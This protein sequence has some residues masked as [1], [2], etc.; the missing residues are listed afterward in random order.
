M[1]DDKSYAMYFAS[2]EVLVAALNGSRVKDILNQIMTQDYKN[3]GL[4]ELISPHR[5]RDDARA[6]LFHVTTEREDVLQDAAD[7]SARMAALRVQ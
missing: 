3:D 7:A 6:S 2:I 4:A 5:Q 1:N